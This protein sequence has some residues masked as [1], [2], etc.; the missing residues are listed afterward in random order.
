MFKMCAYNMYNQVFDWHA[1]RL[2]N[3]SLPVDFPQNVD[4]VDQHFA[5]DCDV[6]WLLATNNNTFYVEE[7]NIWYVPTLFTV[8]QFST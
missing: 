1:S 6:T 8:F 2:L 3:C 5:M 4:L 7:I